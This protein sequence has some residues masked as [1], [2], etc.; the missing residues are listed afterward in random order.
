[1]SYM[2]KETNEI[3][4]F[5]LPKQACTF[6]SKRVKTL[7]DRRQKCTNN[8]KAEKCFECISIVLLAQILNQCNTTL[9]LVVFDAKINVHAAVLLRVQVPRYIMSC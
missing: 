4:S 9:W 7:H 3:L 6:A 8:L 2:M 5:I 1:M